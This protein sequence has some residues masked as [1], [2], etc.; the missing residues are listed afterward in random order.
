LLV[1]LKVGEVSFQLL[2]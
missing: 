1:I 2:H